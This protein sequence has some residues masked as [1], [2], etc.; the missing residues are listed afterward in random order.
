M[1]VKNKLVITFVFLCFAITLAAP[2]DAARDLVVGETRIAEFVSMGEYTDYVILLENGTWR[3]LIS[4]APSNYDDSG[5]LQVKI[6]IASD[7]LFQNI[8]F[9]NSNESGNYPVIDF[10]ISDSRNI[11]IRV[12]ENS[13]YHDTYGWYNIVV[14]SVESPFGI[15]F[16]NPIVSIS[17]IS[18]ISLLAIG[19]V[20]V[21]LFRKP[22]GKPD[23]SEPSFVTEP[24]AFVIPKQQPPSPQK[25]GIEVRTVRVPT[26]CPTCNATLSTATLDWIAPLEASCTYCGAT[27]RATLE[28]M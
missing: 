11:Y 6:I 23:V 3:V 28:K 22:T 1:R 12:K 14:N 17:I 16:D 13:V 4:D 5:N 10:T 27:I 15:A 2:A 20:Y 8:L 18:G 26:I 9:Q 19:T 21:L 24:P 25:D 7:L